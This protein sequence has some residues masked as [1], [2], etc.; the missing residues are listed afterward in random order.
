[1]TATARATSANS[2]QKNS[3]PTQADTRLA[4]RAWLAAAI[5]CT[6]AALS[7]CQQTPAP[8]QAAA[9]VAPTAT[10]TAQPP[11][12]VVP[13]APA[14]ANRAPIDWP[15]LQNAVGSYHAQT[16]FLRQP[17][18]NGRLR[19][20]LGVQY[21]LVMRDLQVAGPLQ[22]DKGVYYVTGNQAHKGG[23]EAVAIAMQPASD[24][25]RVWLLHEGREQVLQ[26]QPNAFAWPAE[27]Q[28]LIQNSAARR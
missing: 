5:G 12:P 9:P 28:T 2:Y 21:E 25:V 17:G 14:S 15:A 11:A 16:Q 13:P 6:L 20:L 1:M 27:V 24:S 18:I 26:E 19:A 7:A 3:E 23:V 4:P 8:P 22:Q 10:A